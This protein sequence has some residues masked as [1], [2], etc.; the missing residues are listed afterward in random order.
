MALHEGL[1]AAAG[2]A[3]SGLAAAG[4]FH[5]GLAGAAAGGGLSGGLAAAAAGGGLSGGVLARIQMAAGM[6][7]GIDLRGNAL[8][9]CTAVST[10]SDVGD[11]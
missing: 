9:G 7:G 1:A 10:T 4:G 5:G 6:M 2:S 11:K 3:G 8:N